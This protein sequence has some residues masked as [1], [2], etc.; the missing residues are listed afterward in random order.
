M[1][2][3]GKVFSSFWI[4]DDIRGLSEDGR[5]LALYLMTSPH[6]NMLGCFRL[7]N[8]Y[9]SDDLQ[10]SFERVSAGF[11]ELSQN[12]FA[13]RCERSYWT[14]IHKHLKWN[15][16]DNENMGKAAAKLFDSFAAPDSVKVI[17]VQA[18]RSFGKN[19]PAQKLADLETVLEGYPNPIETLSK[20]VAVAVEGTVAGTGITTDPVGSVVASVAGD[21]PPAR[22]NADRKPDCPHQ[23]IIALYHEILPMCPSVREW[24][25][26]RATHLRARW[27]EDQKRQNLSYWRAFFEYVATCDF[28]IGKTGSKP[29]LAS[30][31]WMSTAENFTKIREGNYENREPITAKTRGGYDARQ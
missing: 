21:A 16:L 4:S 2:D 24:T 18:L 9:A 29:F 12:G 19:F 31:A 3:Y 15:K 7:P 25:P 22:R 5:A 8:A 26:A 30:L 1:R 23:E 17:L 13:T 10:W 14:V 20:P 11:G 28:L 6:G 27:N